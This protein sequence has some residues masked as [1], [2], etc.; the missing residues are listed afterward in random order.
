MQQFNPTKTAYARLETEAVFTQAD[1]AIYAEMQKRNALKAGAKAL[2][3]TLSTTVQPPN[4]EQIF[5]TGSLAVSDSSFAASTTYTLITY[6]I[7]A[8]CMGVLKNRANWFDGDG[9][10]EG[11]GVLTWSIKVG[12]GFL[13]DHGKILYTIGPDQGTEMASDGGGILLRPNL[14][15]TYQVTTGADISSLSTSGVILARL[16]GWV[17]PAP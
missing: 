9:F 2:Y 10:V 11:S 8:G 13:Y 4:S 5:R 12:N 16:K 3:K 7:P 14:V 1:A 15:V 6:S 17:V